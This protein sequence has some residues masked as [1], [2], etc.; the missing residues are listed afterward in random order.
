M[1]ESNNTVNLQI[2]DNGKGLPA[3]FKVTDS[4]SS[5]GLQ[6]IDTLSQQLEGSYSYESKNGETHFELTFEKSDVK[7]SSNT[8]G[9]IYINIDA[10]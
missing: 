3:D 5:L 6:L 1:T 2:T 8:L 9:N 4:T 7:G 10:D